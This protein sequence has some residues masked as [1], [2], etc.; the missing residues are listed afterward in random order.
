MKQTPTSKDLCLEPVRAS[1]LGAVKVNQASMAMTIML[2]LE[3]CLELAALVGT[4]KIKVNLTSQEEKVFLPN[5]AAKISWV[6]TVGDPA[7]FQQIKFE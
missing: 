1:D 5:S 2:S 6:K 4:I 3:V 7:L